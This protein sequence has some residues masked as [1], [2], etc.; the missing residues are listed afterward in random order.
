MHSV[1]SCS[2]QVWRRSFLKKRT[3][4]DLF[5]PRPGSAPG[6][7]WPKNNNTCKGPWVL[8]PNQVLSKSIKRFW[9]RSW[10]CKLSNG[11]TT[12]DRR[13]T[14]DTIGHWSL[15]LL[16]PKK[17]RHEFVKHGCPRRQQSRNMAKIPKSYILAQPHPRGMWCQWKKKEEIWLNPV[18]KTPTPTEQSKKQ[19]NNIKTPPKTL[20]TQLLW[21]DLGRSV[22]VT[23]VTQLVWLN[24]FTSAQPSH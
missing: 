22:G 5:L 21:T 18:T 14:P 7:I 9:R 3:P 17:T 1:C 15:W 2:L 6:R 19:R 24:R 12:D 4:R 8:H 10:K 11:Q 13:R 16:C 20:I 23:A